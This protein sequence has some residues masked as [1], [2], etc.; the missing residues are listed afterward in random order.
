MELRE[1]RLAIF[2]PT[3]LPSPPEGLSAMSTPSSKLPP[4]FS[5]SIDHPHVALVSRQDFGSYIQ[6]SS[7]ATKNI[8]KSTTTNIFHK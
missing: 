3:S 7:N 8:T 1:A 4:A 5:T 2:P 6:V